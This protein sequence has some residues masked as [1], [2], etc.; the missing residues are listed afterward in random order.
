MG[1]EQGFFSRRAAIAAVESLRLSLMI[2]AVGRVCR[3]LYLGISDYELHG[4]NTSQVADDAST[5]RQWM[6]RTQHHMRFSHRNLSTF[7]QMFSSEQSITTKKKYPSTSYA[8]HMRQ[9]RQRS[10]RLAVQS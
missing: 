1:N 8:L 9:E 6:N 5:K 4:L 10:C 7:A 3:L 2:T